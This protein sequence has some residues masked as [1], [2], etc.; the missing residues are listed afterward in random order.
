MNISPAVKI[1]LL[2]WFTTAT[3]A[4]LHPHLIQ[5]EFNQHLCFQRLYAILVVD[6]L[7]PRWNALTKLQKISN[8]LMSISETRFPGYSLN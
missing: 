4:P 8:E 1:K 2:L 7:I 6:I 5:I 3:I